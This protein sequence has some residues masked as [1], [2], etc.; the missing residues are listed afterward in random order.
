M[1]GTQTRENAGEERQPRTGLSAQ[2]LS[3]RRLTFFGAV[4][5]AELAILFFAMTYPIDPSQQKALMD[6]A[7]GII[8]STT[9]QSPAGMFSDISVNNLRIALLE[10]VP[11]AGAPLFAFSIFTT[12]QVIQALAI[13][14]SIPGPALGLALF[15]FPFAITELSA[16]AIAVSSGTLLVEA[17]RRKTVRAELRVFAIEASVVAAAIILA[18]AMETASVLSPVLSLALWLPTLLGFG[19]LVAFFR[20]G[21]N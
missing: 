3:R 6:Q 18:A 17:W 20:G 4:L 1:S 2:L 5:A 14:M 11:V 16:Y 13:S 9:G 10:M 15:F 19:A 12:G 21:R 8:N 7:S